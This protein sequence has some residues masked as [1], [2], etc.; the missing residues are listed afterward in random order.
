MTEVLD[1]MVA[2]MRARTK[3]HQ[4][5]PKERFKKGDRIRA[6]AGKHEGRVGTIKKVGDAR[7]TME[8]DDG[9][10]TRKTYCEASHAELLRVYQ[11]AR[12]S[13]PPA[14]T[15]TARAT[16]TGSGEQPETT[17]EGIREWTHEMIEKRL[18]EL[19]IDLVAMLRMCNNP[20]VAWKEAKT[21]IDAML[22]WHRE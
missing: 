15:T 3:Y 5:E 9:N 7:L 13:A 10:D 16:T 6:F 4:K 19:T 18:N 1:P 11:E 22:V 20:N 12:A 2:L 8:W 14:L 17:E 21:R